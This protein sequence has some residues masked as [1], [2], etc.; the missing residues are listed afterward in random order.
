MFRIRIKNS[1]CIPKISAQN[2]FSIS[3]HLFSNTSHRTTIHPFTSISL[4]S[5]SKPLPHIISSFNYKQYSIQSNSK[6][7]TQPT[8]IPT[9]QSALTVTEKV[10]TCFSSLFIFGI[11]CVVLPSSLYLVFKSFYSPSGIYKIRNKTFD[12]IQN[13]AELSFVLGDNII[14]KQSKYSIH[15]NTFFDHDNL[16]RCQIIYHISGDKNSA[17]VHV[18]MKQNKENT[19]WTLQYCVVDVTTSSVYKLLEFD[20][21]TK[22]LHHSDLYISYKNKNT[23]NYCIGLTPKYLKRKSVIKVIESACN[24]WSK[25]T[26]NKIKFELIDDIQEADIVFEWKSFD[27]KIKTSYLHT[28]GHGGNGSVE[29][30]AAVRWSVD[31]NDKDKEQTAN[32]N[33]YPLYVIA[34]HEIGHALGL[35]HSFDSHDVMSPSYN[36]NVRHLSRNDS[37][38]FQSLWWI[39]LRSKRDEIEKQAT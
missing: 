22:K 31:E 26:E 36:P 38:R 20:P 27:D 12:L 21:H 13:D 33:I 34:L 19:K 35:E 14:A 32:M 16:K 17:N 6:N 30:N 3:R 1:L 9:G 5:H 39:N 29:F 15:H 24:E 4:Y 8:K 11:L 28:L 23:L 25:V 10:A 37:E 18:E 2:Q 7:K